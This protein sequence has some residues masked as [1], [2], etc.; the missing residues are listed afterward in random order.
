M[1]R[2]EKAESCRTPPRFFVSACACGLLGQQHGGH[3][4]L[5]AV[6]QVDRVRRTVRQLQKRRIV[7]VESRGCRKTSAVESHAAAQPTSC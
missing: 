1:Q 2:R 6:D 3:W 4:H 7:A 5:G